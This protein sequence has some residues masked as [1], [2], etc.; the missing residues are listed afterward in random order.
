MNVMFG[1]TD[2][3]S[4]LTA[5][6]PD[7]RI[8]PSNVVSHASIHARQP[9][10]SAT[11]AEADHTLQNVSLAAFDHVW[12]AR[13]TLASVLSALSVSS[14]QHGA[15]V[16]LDTL[17]SVRR[18]ALRAA[19]GGHSDLQQDGGGVE[20]ALSRQTP[21]GDCAFDVVPDLFSWRRQASWLNGRGEF[22]WSFQLDDGD[23]IEGGVRVVTL[24]VDN[25]RRADRL[26]V[27]GWAVQIMGT[28]ID[29][30]TAP[31]VINAM[32]SSDDVFGLCGISS[33]DQ[34]ATAEVAAGSR[35]QADDPRVGAWSCFHTA[36]DTLVID[37]L[38]IWAHSR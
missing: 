15:R 2:L 9:G 14:A 19:D 28:G 5:H 8:D 21:T 33:A 11:N 36:D 7:L 3:T 4:F 24:V 17:A 16:D 13:V 34:G 38:T 20:T 12:A 23:I 6:R 30:Q 35:A 32:G 22:D 1:Q 26:L 37:V 29:C 10:T 27:G 31:S 18:S 25:V